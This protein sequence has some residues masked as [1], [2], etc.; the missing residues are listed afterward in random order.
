MPT[1]LLEIFGGVEASQACVSTRDL[2]GPTA[3]ALG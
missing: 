1:D 2:A 3:R